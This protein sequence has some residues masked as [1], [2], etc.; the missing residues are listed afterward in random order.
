MLSK[1]L[2]AAALRPIMLSILDRGEAY[3]YAIIRRIEEL[4]DGRIQWTA[5]TLYPLL[6]RLETESLVASYWQPSESGPRRKYYRLT[7]KGAKAL[8][9]EKRQWL[10]VHA[11]LLKLWGP[12]PA[13]G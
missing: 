13:F 1:A 10:D 3:G 2:T 6:H 5:G 9:A 12:E 11:L 7:P 4:S 8:E